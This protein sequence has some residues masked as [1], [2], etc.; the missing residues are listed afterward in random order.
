M[1]TTKTL[2]PENCRELLTSQPEN[3]QHGFV[4][5]YTNLL[6]SQPQYGQ[7]TETDA[8]LY[9]SLQIEPSNA[10]SDIAVLY[11]KFVPEHTSYEPVRYGHSN[12]NATKP[13]SQYAAMMDLLK[14]GQTSARRIE[15]FLQHNE[16]GDNALVIL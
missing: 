1:S 10:S 16:N 3:L 13:I 11:I 5:G 6:I 8:F 9:L 12:G 14:S 4:T 7:P 2:T 15:V